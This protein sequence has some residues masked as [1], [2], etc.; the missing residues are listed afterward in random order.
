MLIWIRLT[1]FGVENNNEKA[2]G[3]LTLADCFKDCGRDCNPG[4]NS[5]KHPLPYSILIRL[6]HFDVGNNIQKGVRELTSTNCF[7]VCGEN[8]ALR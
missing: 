2:T 6:Q 3:R 5:L 4:H 8:V 1:H 7:K